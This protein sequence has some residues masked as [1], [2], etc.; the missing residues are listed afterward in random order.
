MVADWT[1]RVALANAV[2]INSMA[3][4]VLLAMKLTASARLVSI[5]AI[6]QQRVSVRWTV[7]AKAPFGATSAL[8]L[9]CVA[10]R[11]IMALAVRLDLLVLALR[12]LVSVWCHLTAAISPIRLKIMVRTR[13]RVVPA[14]GTIALKVAPA[15]I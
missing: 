11:I 3:G 2:G 12:S 5:Q 6:Q 15:K 13:Q 9:V 10:C 4:T 1:K 7:N 14:G 8:T